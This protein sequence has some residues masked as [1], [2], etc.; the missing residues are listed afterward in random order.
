MYSLQA[1]WTQAREQ[2]HVVTI[3]CAN[4]SYAILKVTTVQSN[5]DVVHETVVDLN[6]AF[7]LHVSG[8]SCQLMCNRLLWW[9]VLQGFCVQ[10][11]YKLVQFTSMLLLWHGHISTAVAA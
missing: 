11:K 7:L 5:T 10:L 8:D 4:R 6:K 9:Q 1:L 2:L 3:I